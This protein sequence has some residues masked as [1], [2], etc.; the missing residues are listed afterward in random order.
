M[1]T[2]TEPDLSTESGALFSPCRTYRYLL[3]RTWDSLPMFPD[4][5]DRIAFC[6]LNPSTADENIND[7]T[8]RRCI[9]FAKR[10]GYR[11]IVMLNLFGLR[12]TQP[13]GLKRTS[14]PV[15]PDN[16]EWLRWAS[17]R[18]ALT[19]CCWGSFSMA[20]HRATAA[21]RLLGDTRCLG[22]NADGQPKHPLYLPNSSELI[23]F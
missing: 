15:G 11:G 14:D 1:T 10:W 21:K 19:V 9:G 20:A 12:S 6:G 5:A 22:T 16:D 4:P 18:V 7:P 13:E 8:I 23:K 3:W 2:S 17:S